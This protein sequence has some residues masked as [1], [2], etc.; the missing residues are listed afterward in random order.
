[1]ASFIYSDW[2]L[3]I[4]HGTLMR[5]RQRQL[6]RPKIER[7]SVADKTRRL[8]SFTQIG[9]FPIVHGALMRDRQRQLERPKIERLSVANK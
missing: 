6:D 7:L 3:P 1:V 5:D 2:W 4:V 8:R 9:G